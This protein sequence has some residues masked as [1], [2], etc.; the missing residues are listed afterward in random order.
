MQ[1]HRVMQRYPPEW[2]ALTQLYA[3]MSLKAAEFSADR[4]RLFLLLELTWKRAVYEAHADRGFL[5]KLL[6]SCARGGEAAA[7]T[8]DPRVGMELWEWLE[9]QVRNVVQ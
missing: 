2:G 6:I 5:V 1:I 3:G 4:E 7:S 8:Q 9:G